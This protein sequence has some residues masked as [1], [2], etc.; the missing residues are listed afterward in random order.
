MYGITFNYAAVRSLIDDECGG[1]G[2]GAPRFHDAIF[3]YVYVYILRIYSGYINIAAAI[4]I[5]AEPR[6]ARQHFRSASYCSEIW[7][8]GDTYNVVADL[9]VFRRIRSNT[10]LDIELT[11]NAIVPL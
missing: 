6:A 4:S 2:G 11:R 3:I 5:Y 10:V 9:M 8:V 7:L 1:G